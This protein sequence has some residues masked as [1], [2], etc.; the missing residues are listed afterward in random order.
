MA[1]KHLIVCCD[2]TWQKINVTY[3]TN[4]AKMK[5]A[6]DAVKKPDQHVFYDSGVGTANFFA[7]WF[8][9]AFGWGLNKNIKDC[10]RY[11]CK[12]YAPGDHLYLFG[13]SRGAYTVRSLGGLLYKCGILKKAKGRL[14]DSA[15]DLYR[16]RTDHPDD[17]GAVAFR[18]N[19][20]FADPETDNRPRI[21]FLGCWDTVGSLG[22][23]DLTPKLKLDKKINAKYKFHDT[24]L[25]RIIRCA[26]HAVAI[27][28]RRKVFDVT[29]MTLSDGAREAGTDLEQ[30]WF[31][32]DHGCIGGGDKAKEPLSDI[33]LFWMMQELSKLKEKTGITFDE[34]KIPDKNRLNYRAAFDNNIEFI[35]KAAGEM[36]RTFTDNF[37]ELF[38]SV[39]AR[40]KEDLSYKP[41]ALRTTFNVAL[42]EWT[43]EKQEALVVGV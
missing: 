5:F 4:V 36:D 29:P 37:N 15:M 9:G 26:R 12:N 30:H 32:G 22:V 28:E 38:W 7:K 2:G 25:S 39:K 43:G 18:K 41:G 10:Y 14:I 35:Y 17:P 42:A 11:L 27:D 40:L 16:D 34:T 20:S 23:P 6:F 1:P 31:T 33:T 24:K 13:F 19:Y 8:G 3:P 21:T